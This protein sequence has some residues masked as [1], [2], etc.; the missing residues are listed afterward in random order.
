MKKLVLAIFIIM[1][2]SSSRGRVAWYGEREFE[3]SAQSIKQEEY[4]LEYINKIDEKTLSLYDVLVICFAEPSQDQKDAIEIF[5]REGGGLLIIYNIISYPKIE[6][7]LSEYGLAGTYEMETGIVF[8][9]LTG[10][11]VEELKKRIAFSQ[12]GRGKVIVVGYDPLTFKTVSLLL[13]I[14]SI[15]SFGIDWLCQD[16]HVD[17]TQKLLAR[18][19]IEIA[20]PVIGVAALLVVGF[21]FY[22]RR[23]KKPEQTKSDK[24]EKVR[25]LK[26]RFV[27]G[28]LSRDEYQREMEKL[29]RSTE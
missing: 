10:S 25:E 28:E 13:D 8:P 16:W 22:K 19:R 14:D 12:K 9:F 26:A 20:V 3:T 7:L 27:Y 5:V 24:L 4:T 6:D 15:F 23:K 1:M 2:L 21:Y 18:K 11:T 29:E 17:Q